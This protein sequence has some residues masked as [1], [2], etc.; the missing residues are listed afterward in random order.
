M[1]IYFA[2]YIL[3]MFFVF[4]YNQDIPKKSNVRWIFIGV[5][6]TIIIGLRDY[7]GGDWNN[8]LRHFQFINY[9]TFDEVLKRSDPGYYI[10]NWVMVDWGY[11]I[12]AVNLI[13]GTI[14]IT[15]LIILCRQQPN[16]WLAFIVAIPYLIVVVAMGYTRQAVAIGFVFWAI[17][18]LRNEQFKQFLILVT[19][20]ATFHKSAV[21]M[22]GLGLFLQGK[23][24]SIRFL[25]VTAIG[26]GIWSAFLAEHQQ[27]L[28]KNYVEANM[29]SQGAF[30]RVAMNFLPAVIFLIFRN[31]WKQ[32]FKDYSF[33]RIIALGSLIS[34]F[35]VNLA[36]TAVDRVSLYFTP[37]QIIVFGRLPQ[38]LKDRVSIKTTTWVIVLFYLLVLFV[39][40]NYATHARFWIP[41]YNI[42]FSDFY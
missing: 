23:G 10:I 17:A 11:E 15:G 32:T 31:Q 25:A 16:P 34:I 5:L 9:Y 41:Y 36:P 30:I 3:L 27:S 20:A 21:L 1:I 13:C 29:Q 22:I 14:F 6:F 38:L 40:L 19:L 33:W 24:K 4:S 28:W 42:L 7:V 39:W 2:M 35:V 18:A 8:Y 37:I 12:Y 26:L